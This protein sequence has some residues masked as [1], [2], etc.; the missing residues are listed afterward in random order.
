MSNSRFV[1]TDTAFLQSTFVMFSDIDCLDT[2]SAVILTFGQWQLDCPITVIFT[3]ALAIQL[4]R[5]NDDMTIDKF[6]LQNR[7]ALI[8]DL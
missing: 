5:S 8:I 3:P 4:N 1:A 7:A 6:L 2:L